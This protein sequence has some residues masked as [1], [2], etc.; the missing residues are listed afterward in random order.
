MLGRTLTAATVDA[1]GTARLMLP[2]DLEPDMYI[3]RTGSQALYLLI[4]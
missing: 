3:V 4:D 1:D 2:A